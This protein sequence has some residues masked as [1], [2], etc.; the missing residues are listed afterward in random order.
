M[1]LFEKA[2][3]CVDFG[4]DYSNLRPFLSVSGP[5]IIKHMTLSE[6]KVYVA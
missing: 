1:E 3:K 6:M 2:K 5:R 4:M